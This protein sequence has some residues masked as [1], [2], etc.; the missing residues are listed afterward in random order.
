MGRGAT[1]QEKRRREETTCTTLYSFQEG[2]IKQPLYLG[3]VSYIK[4]PKH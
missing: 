4:Q 2:H 1:F 3:K